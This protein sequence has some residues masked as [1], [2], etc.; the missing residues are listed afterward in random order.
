MLSEHSATMDNGLV[1]PI[2]YDDWVHRNEVFSQLAAFRHWENRTIEFA[3]GDPEPV[4]HVTASANYFQVLGL[5]PLL[6]RAHGEEKSGGVNEAVLSSEIWRRRFASDPQVLGKTIRISGVPYVVVGVMPS[7]PHN[8]R[9]G[10]GNVWTPIHWYNL[11]S[12]RAASYRARYLRVLARLKPNVT[13]AQAQ[14]RMD[15]LQHQLERE[16]TSVAKGYAVRVESLQDALVGKFRP[17]LLVLLGAVGFVL[18]TACANVANLLLARGIA[19]EKEIAIRVALGAARSGLVRAMLL[20]NAVLASLGA[21]V[22]LGLA[23]WGLWL[24]KYSL[25]SRVPRI[26]EAGLSLPVLL[27]TLFL[28]A[29]SVLLFSL[30]PMLSLGTGNVHETLKEAGRTS[31]GGVRRQR[32]RSLMVMAEFAFAT[33]LLV[34]SGLLLKSFARLLQVHPGFELSQRVVADLVLPANRYDTPAKRTGFYRDLFRRMAETPGVKGAGGELYFPCRSK[35]WLATVWREG[36]NEPRGEEPIVYWNLV[37]GDYFQAMGNPLKRGRLFTEREMWEPGNVALINEAMARQL[38]PGV[39]PLGRRVSGGPGGP[40]NT[41]IGVL[42]DVRQRSLDEP[43]KPEIYYPFSQMPM[44]FLSVVAHTTLPDAAALR[45][46]RGLAQTRDPD[47]VL[48]NLTPLSELAGATIA[49][50]RMAMVLLAVF[51]ALALALSA[52]GM[53]GVMSYA[54][55]QRT[56]EIGIRM[57]IGAGPWD[58]LRLITGQGLRTA[59]AGTALGLLGALAA[60]RALGTLLYG[61]NTM[62][63]TVYSAIAGVAVLVSLTSSFLPARRALGID[64]LVA[65]RKE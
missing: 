49:T 47:I 8:L 57:A 10:W 62:D 2:T 19:R 36:V 6:G 21:G 65:L 48:S 4:L 5:Q 24:L 26:A 41:I 22:G 20:E 25:A 59:L 15:A 29:V 43:P 61:V 40:W 31:G 56:A 37:A 7:A 55:S 51:A 32:L 3:G 42:G 45:V 58:I 52:L 28:M 18:L 12:N 13:M 30:A 27:F 39:D 64:P 50:R 46:I 34:C 54:V 35:L 38:F 17:A 14:G 1:S 60:G 11:E 33:L 53:Y 16:A 63:V 44:P 9:I 23:Y